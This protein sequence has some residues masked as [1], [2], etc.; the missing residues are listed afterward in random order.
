MQHT[1]D[2]L[3]FASL[4]AAFGAGVLSVTYVPEK[5]RSDITLDL[6]SVDMVIALRMVQNFSEKLQAIRDPDP[7]KIE[8]A[9]TG[10]LLHHMNN[11]FV[12]LKRKVVAK[13]HGTP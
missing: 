12:D 1:T 5:R 10:S 2:D 4:L 8:L 13:K 9:Y 11:W 6:D 7:E 3:A